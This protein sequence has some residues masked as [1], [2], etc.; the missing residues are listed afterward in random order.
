[1][2]KNI[3]LFSDGTG[4]SSASPFKTN[5]WRL[6]QAIDIEP[7]SDP[8]HPEQLVYYDNG[9]G[10]ENFKPIAALGGALGI[11]VWQNVKDLYT[12]VCRNYD[13]GD[14]I[15]GF[16]FSRGAFTIR[17]LMGL[18][19]KCGLVKTI[20]EADLTYCVQ[21]AYEAYRR[22]FLIRASR[23][24]NMIYHWILSEPRYDV[25]D[26]RKMP[27][28][29]LNINDCQQLFPDIRFVGVWDTVDAYG[30][31]VDELKF[32]IDEWVWPMSFADR[33]PSDRLLTIRHALS[34]DDERPTFRPVLWNEVLKD[35]KNPNDLNKWKILDF[36]RI[37]QVWFAGVHANVG[38]SY[39]DDGLAFTALNWMMDEAESVGLHYDRLIRHEIAAHVNPDGEQYDSRAGIAGYYRYG[40]RQVAALC[41]DKKHGVAVPAVHVHP[42]AFERIAAWRRDYEPVSLGGPFFVAGAPKAPA[43]SAALENAWDLVWWR[44]I[45]Y[46]TTLV[47]TVFVS[48]FALRLMFAWPNCILTVT[49]AWLNWVWSFITATLG[50][51]L[52]GAIAHAWDWL[53]NNIGA[54]LP[55][56]ATP[57][58]PSF[59]EYPLSGI[60][61]LLLLAWVF[62]IWS[63][64]L[65]R[66]IEVLA[67]WAW[68]G[69]KGLPAAA[70]PKTDWRNIVAQ[71][72]R[73]VTTWLYWWL[74]RGMFVPL[75]GI[76]IG[77]V[78]L[79]VSIVL[80]P[81]WIWSKLRRR[82]WMA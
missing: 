11:G 82:P 23:R 29:N 64:K 43:D 51:T 63:A 17:L 68:A 67:E 78:V 52:T 24:R 32:A 73:P 60:V 15:F 74:W 56:W 38:G 16:G 25:E 37:Q 12:F 34:L 76:V 54:V 28:V 55:G 80:S 36:E 27:T 66:R 62:L 1:M 33:D 58:I 69:H 72:L 6:Y 22:D 35:P 3:V 31:P 47:L 46:F 20:S 71:A 9:V 21:M 26:G 14:Q 50:P 81:I 13:M 48:L 5:V 75:L 77:L 79:I 57:T 19:G 42:A 4:N 39:P 18:I 10:T 41:N 45:A 49:E 2:A 44:R 30:M 61:S 59:R 40:P 65:E 53:L 70:D 8:K 7:P